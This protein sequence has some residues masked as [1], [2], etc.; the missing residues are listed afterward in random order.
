MA[1]LVRDPITMQSDPDTRP[2]QS[3]LRSRAAERERLLEELLVLRA[4]EGSRP[5]FEELVRRWHERLWRHAYRLTGNEQ[6]AADV[7]Q[8]SW[9]G[10]TR[11]I[12]S[13]RDP[14]SFRRWAYTIVTRAGVAALPGRPRRLGALPD[15]VRTGRHGEVAAP[16]HPPTPER[17]PREDAT[18][19]EFNEILKEAF[20][21]LD[22]YDPSPAR[23]DLEA[24]L[25]KFARRDRT[26]RLMLW[27]AVVFMGVVSV[28]AA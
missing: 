23:A 16:S 20:A 14:A 27:F 8:E 12:T 7:M 18:M 9:I 3:E 5:A 15:P 21:G 11:G 26:L 24:S 19:T 28:L 13:L 4:R 6:A 10:V 2:A 17:D 22:P 25:A 1:A